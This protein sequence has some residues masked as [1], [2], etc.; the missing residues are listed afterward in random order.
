MYLM[1]YITNRFFIMYQDI[2]LD[3]Y[4]DQLED[5]IQDKDKDQ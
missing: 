5:I 1:Q 4:K 3:K 2:D